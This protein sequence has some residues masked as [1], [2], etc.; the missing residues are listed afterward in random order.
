MLESKQ[1]TVFTTRWEDI[2]KLVIVGYHKKHEI[3]GRRDLFEYGLDRFDQLRAIHIN[4]HPD[5][6]YNIIDGVETFLFFKK[7]GKQLIAV[8]DHYYD[9]ADERNASVI[10]NNQVSHYS[11]DQIKRLLDLSFDDFMEV[12][13][14]PQQVHNAGRVSLPKALP[15][16]KHVIENIQHINV[17]I[18]STTKAAINKIIADNEYINYPGLMK[19]IVEFHQNGG[20]LW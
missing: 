12:K 7:Q 19:R 5:R 1:H 9:E 18:K 6:M 11:E 2:N 14:T 3:E 10:L 17:A 15:K 16:S 8:Q 20:N 13:S 4:M